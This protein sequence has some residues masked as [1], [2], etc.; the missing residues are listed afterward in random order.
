MSVDTANS[1]EVVVGSHIIE[2]YTFKFCGSDQHE[3]LNVTTYKPLLDNLSR[4]YDLD[5]LNNFHGWN[6]SPNVNDTTNSGANTAEA[7]IANQE[8]Q[9]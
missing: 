6:K 7:S 4:N 8:H 5:F 9:N 1:K 2:E 3:L